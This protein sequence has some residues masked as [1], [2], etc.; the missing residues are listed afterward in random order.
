MK[1]SV[2]PARMLALMH[3][4]EYR[5]PKKCGIAHINKDLFLATPHHLI[6]PM[7]LYAIISFI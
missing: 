4:C 1:T 3:T 5:V 7:L 2:A 6:D